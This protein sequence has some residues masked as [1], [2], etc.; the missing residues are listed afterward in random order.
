MNIIY[1]KSYDKSLKSLKKHYD[2]LKLLYEI[3]DTIKKF[4]SFKE[5]VNDP[6][7]SIYDFERLKYDNNEFYSFRLSKVIRLIIKP[8]DNMC[9]VYLIYIS[10]KH[11]GD[12][13]LGRVIYYDE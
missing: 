10:M 12:F 9:S 3:I 13:D 7:L 11:Y 1:T 4:D 6:L 2:E 5:M 8:H